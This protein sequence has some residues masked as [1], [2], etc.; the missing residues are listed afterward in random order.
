MKILCRIK[1]D[2]YPKTFEEMNDI[3]VFLTKST[4]L[5]ILYKHEELKK[6][7]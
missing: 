6:K 4:C 7:T 2:H 5:Y 1:F 3:Y